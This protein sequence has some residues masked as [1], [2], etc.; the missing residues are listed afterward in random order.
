MSRLIR[1]EGDNIYFND[2]KVAT[3][4]KSA[5]FSCKEDF[6]NA[7]DPAPYSRVPL[8]KRSK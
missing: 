6:K 5:P 8:S 4:D 1:V 2:F 7:I 3:I